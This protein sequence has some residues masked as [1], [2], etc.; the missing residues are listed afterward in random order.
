MSLEDQD[1]NDLIGKNICPVDNGANENE[2]AV[3]NN[4]GNAKKAIQIFEK[5]ASIGVVKRPFGATNSQSKKADVIKSF[6]A[7]DISKQP[8]AI[9]VPKT[10]KQSKKDK[11]SRRSVPKAKHINT[12]TD[13]II[14]ANE[15]QKD[16]K[17]HIAETLENLE[18]LDDDLKKLDNHNNE[19]MEN[20]KEINVDDLLECNEECGPDII[21]DMDDTDNI[22]DGE[23]LNEISMEEAN[24]NQLPRKMSIPQK[25][26]KK[27][28]KSRITL[29]DLQ[30]SIKQVL[31]AQRDEALKSK[32]SI[33]KEHDTKIDEFKQ[34]LNLES[35]RSAKKNVNKP[36]GNQIVN[37][38]SKIVGEV[39]IIKGSV[40]SFDKG[41]HEK[42]DLMPSDAIKKIHERAE[43]IK[44][45]NKNVNI[46][47]LPDIKI[48][49]RRQMGLD[50]Q[51]AYNYENKRQGNRNIGELISS[52]YNA[53]KEYI[54]MAKSEPNLNRPNDIHIIYNSDE[55]MKPKSAS[56]W[57]KIF[58]CG[59][60]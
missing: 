15:A 7:P 42:N 59:C 49:G 24:E 45:S 1:K 11:K 32:K 28:M 38:K 39:V 31:N 13:S 44:I 51:T 18:V 14:N 55:I 33:I 56:L 12:N 22:I 34:Q 47:H 36:H 8:S 2:S 5:L 30:K 3:T 37:K 53:E 17:D 20:D 48:S 29:H 41:G 40:S 54:E 57:E 58:M 52:E 4:I 10:K 19:P 26:S 9:L 43:N 27:E 6:P 25:K 23:A 46:N 35:T 16:S 60:I 21:F 50:N